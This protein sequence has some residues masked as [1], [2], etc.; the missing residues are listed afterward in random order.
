MNVNDLSQTLAESDINQ[1]KPIKH[2]YSLPAP[3]NVRGR[4]PSREFQLKQCQLD[5]ISEE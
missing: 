1:S 5:E 3:F 4:R 2:R